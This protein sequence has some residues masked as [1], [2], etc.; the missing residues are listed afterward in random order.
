MSITTN[1]IEVLKVLGNKYS[2]IL[3]KIQELREH[4]ET[5]EP[6][7]EYIRLNEDDFVASDRFKGMTKGDAAYIVLQ[8]Q[9]ILNKD[10]LFT[11]MKAGGHPAVDVHAVVVAMSA[12]NR[13]RFK[14]LGKG[15]WTLA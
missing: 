15:D 11:I 13:K 8:E 6:N 4:L 12:D 3:N 2:A 9:N 14:S 10:E 1:T 7:T 5:I